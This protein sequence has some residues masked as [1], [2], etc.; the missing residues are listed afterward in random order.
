MSGLV[1]VC[2]VPAAYSREGHREIAFRAER[3]HVSFMNAA[4][5][6]QMPRQE[7]L[8]LMELLWAELSREESE[9]ESP[10][11]HATALRETAERFARGEEQALDWTTAKAE[12]RKSRL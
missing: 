6:Q 4:E 12:L 10:P 9:L 7:K 5:V 8:R 1:P 3:L 2:F 11:W